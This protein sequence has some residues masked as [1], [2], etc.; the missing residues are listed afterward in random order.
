MW[1]IQQW[2][3]TD[4]EKTFKA[5]H[6][7]PPHGP[8]RRTGYVVVVVHVCRLQSHYIHTLTLTNK[9]QTN[10]KQAKRDAEYTSY[11]NREQ[12]VKAAVGEIT[13]AALPTYSSPHTRRFFF[14][15]NW[16]RVHTTIVHFQL[17]NL[18]WP[19][20]SNEVYYVSNNQVRRFNSV[21]RGRGAVGDIVI[22]VSA[23]N[24]SRIP[25][26][27]SVNVCTMCAKYGVVA[28]GGF[29][30]ELVVRRIPHLFHDIG[31]DTDTNTGRTI[32]SGAH[33]ITTNKTKNSLELQGI[34]VTHAD[35]G[36]TNAIDVYTPAT[37]NSTRLVCSNNDQAVRVF[38][39]EGL[40]P[41]STF[42]L[43]WAVNC[44]V[45]SPQGGRLY[46][47]VGDDP[48]GVLLDPR[49]VSSPSSTRGTSTT[50]TEPLASHEVVAKLTGHY[51]FSFAAAWHP[52]GNIV[53]TGNQDLTT[54][55]FDLRVTQKPLCVLKSHVG[56][57]RSL[58]FSPD[59]R[60][61]AVAEPAD[62]VT[63]YDVGTGYRTCQSIDLFGE[64]AGVGFTPG[65]NRFYIAV[66]DV[67]YASLVQYNSSSSG[68][69]SATG[70]EG[71]VEGLRGEDAW[72]YERKRRGIDVDWRDA[73]VDD[74]DVAWDA[75]DPPY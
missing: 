20:S 71:Y 6:G 68:S 55:I 47:A 45:A 58:R 69:S 74:Y 62:Y 2:R 61:L 53:A 1:Q 18:I 63:L 35:N 40:C 19:T 31:N 49:S 12:E 73:P 11:Y 4:R 16:R 46:C 5:F 66:A 72:R 34:R 43:P 17:R 28:A 60:T 9:K 70:V 30:G 22:D 65:S 15:R 50:V 42:S 33:A 24:R 10:K 26:M 7:S 39:V 23:A 59:G 14:Y 41:V 64:L 3:R 56:A 13:A 27:D 21:A 51:D 25:G 37:G 44:C 29:G 8:E 48:E 75:D 57:V 38:D 32:R 52:D 67:H 36:I 54:R